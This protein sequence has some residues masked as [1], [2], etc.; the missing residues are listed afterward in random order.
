VHLGPFAGHVTGQIQQQ[1]N[2]IDTGRWTMP[3]MLR[4]AAFSPATETAAA[5]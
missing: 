2:D 3:E 4:D 5:E 1:I